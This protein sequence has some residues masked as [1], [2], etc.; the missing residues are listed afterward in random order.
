[1][2]SDPVLDA[3]R[4]AELERL[5]RAVPWTAVDAADWNRRATPATVL[6][7]VHAARERDRLRVA[8]AE[9]QATA[10][11]AAESL[12]SWHNHRAS[13]IGPP[14]RCPT[15]KI[16]ARLKKARAALAGEDGGDGA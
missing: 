4:L 11:L 2:P 7:L 10:A 6:A 14:D 5:A 16:V 13:T 1:M 12:A 15:C 3:A 8:L 9:W